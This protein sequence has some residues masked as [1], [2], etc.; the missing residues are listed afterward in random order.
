[1]GGNKRCSTAF[2]LSGTLKVAWFLDEVSLLI[3]CAHGGGVGGWMASGKMLLCRLDISAFDSKLIYMKISTHARSVSF[4]SC[5]IFGYAWQRSAR[6]R[7]QDFLHFQYLYSVVNEL[8]SRAPSS[9]SLRTE[10]PF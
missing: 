1:V 10:Y 8:A 3:C 4:S 9:I 7:E 5:L 2:Y 6:T